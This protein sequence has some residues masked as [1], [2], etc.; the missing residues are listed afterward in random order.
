M[1]L[2]VLDSVSWVMYIMNSQGMNNIKP[3]DTK[4]RSDLLSYF[5]HTTLKVLGFNFLCK[6]EKNDFE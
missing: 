6:N 2:G 1:R 3:T 4:V 5:I